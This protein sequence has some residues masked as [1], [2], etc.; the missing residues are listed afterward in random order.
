MDVAQALSHL[1]SMPALNR[2]LA[3]PGPSTHTHEYLLELV[4]TLTYNAPS[5]APVVPKRLALALARTAQRIWWPAL[6]PDEVE[7]RYIDDNDADTPGDW[8]A[9]GVEPDEIENHAIT[10]L[11][12]YRSACV[13][14]H[15]PSPWSLSP[16]S[17]AFVILTQRELYPS[18]RSA[19][20]P[21]KRLRIPPPALLCPD[22]LL[23]VLVELPTVRSS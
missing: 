7:R 23:L 8:A 14:A 19:L 22:F 17:H 4:S 3:L 5:R 2:T 12:R 10:Y 20:T 18:H 11:R 6:C 9:V 1:V 16:P 15:F 13:I 21:G